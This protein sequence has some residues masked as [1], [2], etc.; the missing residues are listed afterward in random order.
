M[1]SWLY[2]DNFKKFIKKFG[3]K[4]INIHPSLFQSIKVELLFP[5]L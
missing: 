4:I 2:E 3:K 5:E 1:F